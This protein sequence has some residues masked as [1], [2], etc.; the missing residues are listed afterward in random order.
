MEIGRKE[1][2]IKAEVMKKEGNTKG[3]RDVQRDQ[4][5]FEERKK[6]PMNGEK[7]TGG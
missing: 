2:G 5:E 3:Y 1:R 4:N 6:W 7:Q